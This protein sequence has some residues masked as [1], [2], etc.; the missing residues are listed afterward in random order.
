MIEKMAVLIFGLTVQKIGQDKMV[1]GDNGFLG[2]GS[3]N[4][5]GG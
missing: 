4:N 5:S 2:F 3:W 1:V